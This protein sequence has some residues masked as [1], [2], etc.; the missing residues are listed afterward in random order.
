MTI[1]RRVQPAPEPIG[2]IVNNGDGTFKA[3]VFGENREIGPF[4]TDRE[5]MIALV[6]DQG[7]SS[8]FYQD[9][10]PYALRMELQ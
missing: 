7:C 2:D 8:E 6:S 9:P 5:A 1:Y 4:P 10:S 3:V